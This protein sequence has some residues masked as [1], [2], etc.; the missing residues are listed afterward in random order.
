VR[1]LQFVPFLKNCSSYFRLSV[2][3][4]IALVNSKFENPPEVLNR[5][6]VWGVRRPFHKW[7]SEVLDPILGINSAMSRSSIHHK[8]GLPSGDFV[9]QPVTEFVL[10][11]LVELNKI[12][13]NMFAERLGFNRTP[14]RVPDHRKYHLERT[15]NRTKYYDVSSL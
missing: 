2:G 10:Q 15:A 5:I 3:S 12:W 8:D 9:W 13:E 1:R 6:E 14:A 7:D 11:F 4:W